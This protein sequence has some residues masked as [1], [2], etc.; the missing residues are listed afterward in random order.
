MLLQTKKLSDIV[1]NEVGKNT[2]LN[3]LKTKQI[4]YEK[5]FLIQL[6]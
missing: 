5:R 6:R 1:A 4:A 3:T 2:K